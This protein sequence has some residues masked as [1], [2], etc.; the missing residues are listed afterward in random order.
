MRTWGN[1]TWKCF[2]FIDKLTLTYHSDSC[3]LQIL[4]CQV[5]W[6]KN[7]KIIFHDE[8]LV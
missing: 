8:K 5:F 2:G 7:I 3:V 6:E 4:S 1:A